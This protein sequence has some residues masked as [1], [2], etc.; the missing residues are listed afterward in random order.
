MTL[1]VRHPRVLEPQSLE[2]LTTVYYESMY[3]NKDEAKKLIEN[4]NNYCSGL[5]SNEITYMQTYMV[6]AERLAKRKKKINRRNFVRKENAK[7]NKKISLEE[8]EINKN[9]YLKALE[10][11]KND[12]LKKTRKIYG[13]GA[14]T[15]PPLASSASF[16]VSCIYFNIP[17]EP[18]ALIAGALGLTTYAVF[19]TFESRKSKKTIQKC[20]ED[21]R[22]TEKYCTDRKKQIE[23]EY[24]SEILKIEA[25]KESEI[26]KHF[27]RG[28]RDLKKAWKVYGIDSK[29]SVDFNVMFRVLG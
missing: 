26:K 3:R 15:I 25:D 10:E 1:E 12:E 29:G 8:A 5:N 21:E 6:K 27:S 22:G 28:V 7:F 19:K 23:E 24:L 18:S 16:A 11:I 20:C 17:K 14:K 9:R 13:R 2:D 4:L